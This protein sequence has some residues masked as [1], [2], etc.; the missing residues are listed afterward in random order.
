MYLILSVI[1]ITLNLLINKLVLNKQ[2]KG[3]VLWIRDVAAHVT[4]F[5]LALMD[6]YKRPSILDLNIIL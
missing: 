6:K 4:V 1:A 3:A 2:W 5:K